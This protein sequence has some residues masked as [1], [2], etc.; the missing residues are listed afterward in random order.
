MKKLFVLLVAAAAA[1]PA[2]AGV[3]DN[4]RPAYT[5]KDVK[6][7]RDLAYG[8]RVDLPTEG[9]GFRKLLGGWGG[10]HGIRCGR[11]R[12]GQTY[13]VYLPKTVTAETPV[14]LYVHGGTWSQ[15]VDKDG[16]S[17]DLLMALATRGYLVFSMDYL[18]QNDLLTGGESKPREGATFAAMLADV[19]A[20][21]AKV[22]EIRG[23]L[24]ISTGKVFMGGVS[25]GAHLSLL[26]GFDE[27]DA[28]RLKLPLRH[29]LPL[30]GVVDIVGPTDFTLPKEVTAKAFSFPLFVGSGKKMETLFG[31]LL[32]LKADD[33]PAHVQ[34][35]LKRYSPAHMVGTKAP[36]AILAYAETKKG[37]NTDS[38]LSLQNHTSITNAL[39]AK[40]LAFA[41]KIFVGSNH[42]SLEKDAI[43]FVLEEL[44]KLR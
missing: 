3:L 24:K 33:D 27:G 15:M 20:M 40:N 11:H 21:M 39:T 14:F 34:S 12:T 2:V 13:D 25:A 26:Y 42:M 30:A 6:V 43:P 8:P 31:W 7:Y 19:D 41:E 37:S 35:E 9:A 4:L 28:S 22:A 17:V 5:E 44:E 32:G 36:K 29:P 10:P 23:D 16:T 1:W 38:I 18:L